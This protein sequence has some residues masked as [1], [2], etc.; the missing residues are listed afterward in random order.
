MVNRQAAV[1]DEQQLSS[2]HRRVVSAKPAESVFGF[3]AVAV[4]VSG[5]TILDHDNFVLFDVINRVAPC[6]SLSA[7]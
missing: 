4:N 1:I 7:L 3:L 5:N 6:L 2:S